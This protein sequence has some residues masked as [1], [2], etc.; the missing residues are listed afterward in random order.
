VAKNVLDMQIAYLLNPNTN[1]PAP[2]SNANWIIGD[3]SGTQEQPLAPTAIPFKPTYGTPQTDPSTFGPGA[4][5]AGNVRGV[6]VQL[7]IESDGRDQTQAANWV[8][9]SSPPAENRTTPVQVAQHR[10]FRA[11]T[12]I[13]LRNME[14][15]TPAF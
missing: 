1:G 2:D 3:Q 9:D 12:S 4:L 10:I 7:R 13:Y 6:R 15:A 14:S 11:E 8:G 5:A